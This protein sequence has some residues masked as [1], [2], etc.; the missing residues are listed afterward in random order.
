MITAPEA[1]RESAKTFEERNAI[2]GDN[3]K[4]HGEV[5]RALFPR[6]VTLTSASDFNRYGLVVQIVA[7]VSRYAQQFTNGGHDDSLLDLS[8]YAAMLREVDSEMNDDVKT[9]LA[10]ILAQD[11]Q[12]RTAP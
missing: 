2:Y 4:L 1:L 8:T 9:M 6:G 5:M 11:A 3:Y 12:R 10:G 7:K